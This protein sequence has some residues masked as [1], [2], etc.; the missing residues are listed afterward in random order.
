M[1][2]V[3]LVLVAACFH[4]LHCS[5][6]NPPTRVERVNS[7]HLPFQ[8]HDIHREA[9]IATYALLKNVGRNSELR[10]YSDNLDFNKSCDT[11]PVKKRRIS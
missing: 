9:R 4:N 11:P 1:K 5:D 8:N 10:T 7:E 2:K 3:L 6:A